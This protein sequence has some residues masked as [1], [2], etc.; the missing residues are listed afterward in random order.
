MSLSSETGEPFYFSNAGARLFGVYHPSGLA[1]PAQAA[2]VICAPW[3]PEYVRAHRALRQLALRLTRCGCGVIRFDYTGCGDSEGD[4]EQVGLEQW[5]SDIDAAIGEARRRS[6]ARRVFLVGLRLGAALAWR[7]AEQR[8]DVAGLVLWEPV[9]AGAAYLDELTDLQRQTLSRYAHRP[10]EMSDGDSLLERLGFP[11][12]SAL[13]L[14]LGALELRVANRPPA[15]EV[16][17]VGIEQPPALDAL[18]QAL[19]AARAHVQVDDFAEP[20]IW[21]EDPD[22]ALVPL[23]TLEAIVGW[24][25]EGIA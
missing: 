19:T 4:D 7:A 25:A 6:G 18:R 9:L 5:R 1:G 23:R 21:T 17:I 12:S 24:I 14:D 13:A 3:G 22:K 16:L 11:I 2:V 20:R 15:R 10:A 8:E